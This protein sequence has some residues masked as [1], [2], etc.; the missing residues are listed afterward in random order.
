MLSEGAH[1]WFEG[2]QS[3]V[4]DVIDLSSNDRAVAIEN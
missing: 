4:T 2:E 3:K 1:Q